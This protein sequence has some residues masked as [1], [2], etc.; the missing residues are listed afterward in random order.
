MTNKTARIAAQATGGTSYQFEQTGHTIALRP[1]MHTDT[2]E[3]HN[4]D[5]WIGD[6]YDVIPNPNEALA[7]LGE[8]PTNPPQLISPAQFAD[9]ID[10]VEL[11]GKTTSELAEIALAFS[12]LCKNAGDK[13]MAAA[14]LELHKELLAGNKE[15]R[16]KLIELV[17]RSA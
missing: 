11:S 12:T 10:S 2:I 4:K 9:F 8:T 6:G 1:G 15:L 14:W 16:D 5:L 17:R 13:T 3:S 7:E